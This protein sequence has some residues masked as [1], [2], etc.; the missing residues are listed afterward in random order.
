M[1][2]LDFYTV[3]FIIVSL[4]ASALSWPPVDGTKSFLF[5]WCVLTLFL[6]QSWIDSKMLLVSSLPILFLGLCSLSVIKLV[7]ILGDFSVL[8]KKNPIFLIRGTLDN[9]QF[10][11]KRNMQLHTMQKLLSWAFIPEI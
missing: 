1:G 11:V 7:F 10:L 2:N 5:P 6:L 9:W 3:E 8:E 4:L